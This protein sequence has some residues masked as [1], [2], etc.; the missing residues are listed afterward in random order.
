MIG[1]Q[2]R[3]LVAPDLF[4]V[5]YVGHFPQAVQQI[6]M[7]YHH[8]FGVRCGTRRVL[9]K[10]KPVRCRDRTLPPRG[11]GIGYRIGCQ[12]LELGEVRVLLRQHFAQGQDSGRGQRDVRIGVIRND[13]QTGQAAIEAAGVRRISGTATSGVKT[14]KECGHIIQPRRIHEQARSPGA[15]VSR[16]WQQWRGRRSNWRTC[17][18]ALQSRRH[19][20]TDTPF[21]SIAF[22]LDADH[23]A[24]WLPE[25]VSPLRASLRIC[26]LRHP[27][28]LSSSFQ[29]C[30]QFDEKTLA[31]NYG[32][33]HLVEI[34]ALA[35]HGAAAF[36]CWSV[37]WCAAE[38]DKPLCARTSCV[39]VVA[40]RTADTT[41]RSAAGSPMPFASAT[42]ISFSPSPV[43]PKRNHDPG[44]IVAWAS[45]Q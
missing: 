1:G 30:L 33:E 8:A 26:V 15:Q 36:R 23:F 13:F 34:I 44:R 32:V 18:T 20:G 28:W 41:A 29:Y 31:D 10:R 3:H 24:Q 5:P 7:R 14:P 38:S 27:G 42:T 43:R 19:R 40:V 4:R 9:Q 6:A 16:R 11:I 22:R 21:D 2:P 17:T 37:Q 45:R 39:C 25:T 35:S 12:P